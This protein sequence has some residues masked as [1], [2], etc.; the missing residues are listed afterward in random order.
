MNIKPHFKVKKVLISIFFCC[1]CLTNYSQSQENILL[2]K[3]D[4]LSKAQKD[5][6]I[7]LRMY[8]RINQ[9]ISSK[10]SEVNGNEIKK[11]QMKVA[12]LTELTEKNTKFFVILYIAIFLSTVVSIIFFLLYK[13]EREKANV[14]IPPPI[15][16]IEDNNSEI[17]PFEIDRTDTS[18]EYRKLCRLMNTDKVYLDKKLQLSNLAE[19]LDINQLKLS[20]LISTKFKRSYN[21]FINDYR[22]KYACKLLSDPKDSKRIDFIADECGFSYRTTFNIVFKKHTGMTPSEYKRKKGL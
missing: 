7:K 9:E 1:F 12:E 21:D 3:I 6:E 2:K 13:K 10:Q 20:H 8:E 18:P 5:A 11:Y 19:M 15:P 14:Q 4:S 17:L 22:I 16:V